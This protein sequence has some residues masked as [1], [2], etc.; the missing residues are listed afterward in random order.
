MQKIIIFLLGAAVGLFCGWY[1]WGDSQNV[2]PPENVVCLPADS[3][4]NVVF[5]DSLKQNEIAEVVDAAMFNALTEKYRI[6]HPTDE[7]R[8]TGEW[9]GRI[10]RNALY[11]ALNN[12]GDNPYLNY[13]FAKDGATGQ[14][15]VIFKSEQKR[16]GPSHD[17]AVSAVARTLN[18]TGS[19]KMY[20]TGASEDHYC[21]Q[22]CE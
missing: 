20:K 7:T 11:N 6:E 8:P 2:T 17:A 10:E 16:K 22:K 15:S 14:V 18:P 1:I 9:G 3:L 5:N 19:V 4:G 12:L 13:Y 21:P